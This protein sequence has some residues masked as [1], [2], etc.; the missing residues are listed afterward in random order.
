ME[1]IQFRDRGT[2]EGQGES[3]RG[4]YLAAG[5][6]RVF[7]NTQF[8]HDAVLRMAK[9]GREAIKGAGFN[10]SMVRRAARA[11]GRHERY[12]GRMGGLERLY[13]VAMKGLG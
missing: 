3:E 11:V 13:E 7:D 8:N 1:R 4:V 9:M 5:Y 12:K 6:M 10:R 2:G